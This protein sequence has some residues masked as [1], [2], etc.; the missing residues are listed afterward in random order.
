M[1]SVANSK[2]VQRRRRGAKKKGTYNGVTVDEFGLNKNQRRFC[3]A[4][5]ADPEEDRK[6][7]FRAGG[8]KCAEKNISMSVHRVMKSKAVQAYLYQRRQRL[9][10]NSQIKEQHLLDELGCIAFFDPADL[11]DVNGTLKSIQEIPQVARKAIAQLDVFTE[12]EGRGNSRMAVGTT[13][14]IKFVDKKGAIDTLAR[15]LGLFQQDKID[16]D[17]VAKLMDLVAQSR[18]GSTIGRLNT[19]DQSGRPVRGS[20]LAAEQPLLDSKQGRHAGP[21]PS[22][23]RAGATAGKLLVHELHTEGEAV[24]DDDVHRP[25][26]TG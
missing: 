7:A 17:G 22:Q 3:D 13:T 20:E 1:G 2:T 15:M 10:R 5:L 25:T 11:F 12:Y 19:I 23:L 6:K 26:V 14:R 18:G 9:R 24:G 16:T 8:W 4:L 21:L